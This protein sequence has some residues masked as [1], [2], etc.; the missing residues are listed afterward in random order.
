MLVQ[1]AELA[2]ANALQEE[3]MKLVRDARKS[4]LTVLAMSAVLLT[5]CG[6]GGDGDAGTPPPSGSY[7]AE[8]A[9]RNFLSTQRAWTVTGRASDGRDWQFGLT[10]TPQPPAV[11]G[12]TG[13]TQSRQQ[14][15]VTISVNGV[16]AGSDAIT[17]HYTPNPLRMAGVLG[18]DG[19]CTLATTANTPPAAAAVNASGLLYE[20]PGLSSCA[21][22]AP[23][24]ANSRSVWSVEAEAGFALFCLNTEG[25]TPQ[26]VVVGRES[27]CFE[28]QPDGTL[29]GRARLSI[30]LFAP[31]ALTV[32]AKNY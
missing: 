2:R 31:Q 6:G 11:F 28:V 4:V 17:Y 8:A 1:R 9:L 21:P 18:S 29:G 23:A 24:V 26:G 3:P 7:N 16:F 15:S 13:I 10:T 14:F 12:A 20:G 25:T 30:Q 22:G 19:G 5:A 27:D 32:V